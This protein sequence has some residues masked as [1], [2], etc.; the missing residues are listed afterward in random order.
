MRT[1]AVVVACLVALLAT[2]CG[3]VSPSHGAGRSAHVAGGYGR[4]PQSFAPN[5]G[6]ADRR[7]DFLSRGP[8]YAL[9]LRPDSASL[10]LSRHDARAMVRM[11]LVGARPDA[12]AAPGARLPGTV[13][14]FRGNRPSRWRTAIP[15][16]GAV[17]YRSVYPGV[18]VRY[19]GDQGSLEYD[20]TLAPR[21]HAGAIALDFHGRAASR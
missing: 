6:L 15:T 16:Y 5:R 9:A 21:A 1:P 14:S 20:F 11:Q 17:A 19:H 4:L 13:N 8:G 7:Y 2:G 12:R 3:S 18:D 10:A